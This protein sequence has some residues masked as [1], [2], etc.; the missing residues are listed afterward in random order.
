VGRDMFTIEKEDLKFLPLGILTKIDALLKPI[1]W[2]H[3]EFL[4]KLREKLTK[5]T[6]SIR[7]EE[8]GIFSH[9]PE[10]RLSG[11]RF[12]Q[13]EERVFLEVPQVCRTFRPSGK[14]KKALKSYEYRRE[15]E[16]MAEAV[17]TALN[18]EKYLIV[19]AGT[20]VGKSWAYL[21]P[22]ILWAKKNNQH[23]IISTNTKNLQEQ[24]VQKDIPFLKRW[25]GIDFSSAILKG[26]ANYLCLRRLASSIED[27]EETPLPLFSVEERMFLVHLLVWLGKTESGDVEEN[28]YFWQQPSFWTYW[29]EVSSEHTSC[30]GN[31]CPYYRRCFVT[32]ARQKAMEAEIVVVNHSLLFTDMVAEKHFLPSYSHIVFDEAHNLEKVATTHLAVEVS[33]WMLLRLLNRI[34]RKEGKTERGILVKVANKERGL[35]QHL[36]LMF[37]KMPEVKKACKDFF[38]TLKQSSNLFQFDEVTNKVRLR[39]NSP[40]Q[41]LLKEQVPK[42][43]SIWNQF[44]HRLGELAEEIEDSILAKD[45][46]GRVKDGLQIAMGLNFLAEAD[47]PNFVYWLEKE[48]EEIKLSAAPLEVGPY[49]NNLLY[50]QVPVVVFSSATLTVKGS[51]D[52]LKKRLGLDLMPQEKVSFLLLGSP[53]D[54]ERQ[55]LVSIASF[56]P[57][58]QEEEEY[59]GQMVKTLV[60]VLEACEG[61]SLILFT[62]H[63]MLNAVYQNIKPH[64]DNKFQILAQGINGP[65]T[66]ITDKFKEDFSSILLGTHS[67]WEGVDLPGRTLECLILTRLPF[68][69]PTEPIEEARVELIENRGLDAFREYSLPSAVIRLRQGIGRLIRSGTDKGIIIILDK[70]IIIRNYGKSF[71]DSLPVRGYHCYSEEDSLLEDI[72]DWLKAGTE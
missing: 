67:F 1:F 19:E 31:E 4:K 30:L 6:R 8:E 55:V 23:F 45:V 54:Y 34:Y 27:I 7:G 40:A 2:Q 69:V 26:R 52:F 36:D 24:L 63:K 46:K 20:G 48:K 29:D 72:R 65:R 70:R 51:F 15:Q 50:S 57:S 13:K 44:F 68:A 5:S 28:I 37:K 42:L 11:D 18:E 53:F 25:L 32:K 22:A 49:L 71:L 10:I 33:H 61:K 16:E 47:D 60:K 3:K 39:E 56:L 66:I 64:L 59:T 12:K 43:L 17:A 9:L 21:I 38:E 14:L 58:P 35:R 62:S 41:Y